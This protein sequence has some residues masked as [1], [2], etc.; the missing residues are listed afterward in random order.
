LDFLKYYFFFFLPSIYHLNKLKANTLR[1]LNHVGYG[2]LEC[3]L[4]KT[5]KNDL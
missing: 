3:R 4:T 5:P 2:T 1:S